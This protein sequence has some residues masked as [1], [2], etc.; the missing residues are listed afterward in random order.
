MRKWIGAVAVAVAL[1][2]WAA[3]G[4]RRDICP[5]SDAIECAMARERGVAGRSDVIPPCP[6]HPSLNGRGAGAFWALVALAAVFLA[7]VFVFGESPR[8]PIQ[9]IPR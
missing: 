9:G 3:W 6:T 2:A 8:W 4:P 1:L 5:W 7:M